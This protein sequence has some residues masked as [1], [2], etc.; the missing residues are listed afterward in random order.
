MTRW[1]RASFRFYGRARAIARPG[2]MQAVEAQPLLEPVAASGVAAIQGPY[3][4]LEAAFQVQLA[5]QVLDVDFDGRVRNSELA[6]DLLVAVPEREAAQNLVFPLGEL[7]LVL[8]RGRSRGPGQ[9]GRDPAFQYDAAAGS[10]FEPG[11]QIFRLQIL[12]Q[13]PIG[14][15]A[16]R[17][18]DVAFVVGNRQH[19]AAGARVRL[20]DALQGRDARHS[21]HVQIDQH[22]VRRDLARQLDPARAV[23]GFTDELQVGV[24]LDQLRHAAPEQGVVVSA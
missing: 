17:L 11:A 14:A 21:L 3:R 12:Q 19:D 10:Q 15:G 7:D 24:R 9:H 22:D 4:G 6:R 8:H 18:Q 2:W 16:H 1:T 23:A 20:L 5:Q 13:I